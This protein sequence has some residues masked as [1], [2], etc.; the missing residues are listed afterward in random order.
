MADYTH[1]GAKADDEWREFVRSHPP[2]SQPEDL[3]PYKE[4]F[5]SKRTA[6]FQNVIGPVSMF[7]TEI[8]NPL[9]LIALQKASRQRMFLYHVV[10]VKL[11]PEEYIIQKMHHHPNVPCRCTFM[12]MVVG[13]S[14]AA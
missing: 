11:S 13:S 7:P 8:P 14:S 6:L 3:V 5:N 1:Y 4:S 12:Y 10:M 9:F 2:P